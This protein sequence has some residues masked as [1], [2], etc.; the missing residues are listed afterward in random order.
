[1]IR[2]CNG[3]LCGI[4]WLWLDLEKKQPINIGDDHQDIYEEQIKYCP[5]EDWIT[6]N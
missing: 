1:M 5:I 6:F 3:K 4:T 2:W